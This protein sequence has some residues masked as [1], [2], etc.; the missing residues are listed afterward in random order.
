MNTVWSLEA[1]GVYLSRRPFVNPT[2]VIL[3]WHILE[4]E[5]GLT[6]DQK[7]ISTNLLF[8]TIIDSSL[9]YYHVQN[10]RSIYPI[11]LQVWLEIIP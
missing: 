2:V 9:T 7:L 3:F 5:M 1:T 4:T 11:N 6:W 8:L 10:D